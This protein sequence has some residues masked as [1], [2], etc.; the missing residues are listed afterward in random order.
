MDGVSVV[1]YTQ[2][3][4]GAPFNCNV[5]PTATAP[6]STLICKDQFDYYLDKAWSENNLA[7]LDK[8]LV[9]DSTGF[10]PA[11]SHASPDQGN[12]KVADS[13]AKPTPSTLPRPIRRR[14]RRALCGTR[15]I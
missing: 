10:A 3:A 13:W 8:P 1:V 9:L 4:N 2:H 6:A 11:A 7:T 12:G 5:I 14:P 15:T